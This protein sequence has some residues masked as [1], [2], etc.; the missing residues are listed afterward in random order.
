[1]LK[2]PLY[3]ALFQAPAL[4]AAVPEIQIGVIHL[5]RKN[6]AEHPL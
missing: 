4:A 3:N 6:L 5:V 2:L 1:M